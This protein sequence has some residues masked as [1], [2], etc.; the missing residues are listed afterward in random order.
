MQADVTVLMHLGTIFDLWGIMFNE[1]ERRALYG[2]LHLLLPHIR[3]DHGDSTAVS[4]Q[5]G[6]YSGLRQCYA[7]V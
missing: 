2:T 5:S 4:I 6:A 3:Q 1:D 7:T